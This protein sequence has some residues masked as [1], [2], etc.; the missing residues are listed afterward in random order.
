MLGKKSEGKKIGYLGFLGGRELLYRSKISPGGQTD[1]E[2]GRSI[3]E[4]LGKGLW[5][6]KKQKGGD[7]KRKKGWESQLLVAAK[8]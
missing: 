1:S 3:L 2:N 4:K 5:H 7:E 6:Q 8:I